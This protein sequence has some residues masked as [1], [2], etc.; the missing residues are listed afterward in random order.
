[1][2]FV[3]DCNTFTSPRLTCRLTSKLSNW[4]LLFISDTCPDGVRLD[5]NPLVAKHCLWRSALA[6]DR[7]A[8]RLAGPRR[9]VK[10][11]R[12]RGGCSTESGA[13]APLS[14]ERPRGDSSGRPPPNVEVVCRS[15]PHEDAR[16]RVGPTLTLGRASSPPAASLDDSSGTGQPAG[17]TVSR[18]SW[19]PQTMLSYKRIAIQSDSI[20]A[21][22]WNKQKWS[23]G[24][25]RCEAASKTGTCESVT[26]NNEIH[27]SVDQWF[28]ILVGS[29]TR[30]QVCKEILW[31][32]FEFFL[33]LV[34][35]KIC[36]GGTDI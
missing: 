1:M 17:P 13:S 8:G 26:I 32:T 16:P 10:A 30:I 12:G 21:G 7:G 28:S 34:V 31:V 35:T 22:V 15:S 3:I 11:G 5:R 9:V 25:F 6:T 14:V 4:S 23:V 27:Q 20:G 2:Y 29:R 24:Q 18:Q 33:K 19:P 36:T